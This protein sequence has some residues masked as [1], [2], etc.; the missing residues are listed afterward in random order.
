MLTNS[1]VYVNARHSI[2]RYD[3]ST[4]VQPRYALGLGRPPPAGPEWR[5]RRLDQWEAIMLGPAHPRTALLFHLIFFA[6]EIFNAKP[7]EVLMSLQ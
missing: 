1:L 2:N 7:F 4:G 5:R 6:R 3:L